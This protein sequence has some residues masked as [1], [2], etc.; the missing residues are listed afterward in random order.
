MA[1]ASGQNPDETEG[2]IVKMLQ[3]D[4]F[5]DADRWTDIS[6]DEDRVFDP[7]EGYRDDSGKTFA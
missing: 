6:E 4:D 2:G 1:A 7:A 5:D 3:V